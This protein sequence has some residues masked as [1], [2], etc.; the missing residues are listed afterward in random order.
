MFVNK[1]P[2]ATK[3]HHRTKQRWVLSQD[4]RTKQEGTKT[5]SPLV[6]RRVAHRQRADIGCLISCEQLSLR[7]KSD[8]SDSPRTK[9]ALKS[10]ECERVDNRSLNVT[11]GRLGSVQQDLWKYCPRELLTLKGMFWA[12]EDS[13]LLQ[14]SVEE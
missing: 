8:D 1:V 7:V 6:L 4:R 11:V 5:S 3:G 14:I 12:R 2:S 9:L 10:C 13:R